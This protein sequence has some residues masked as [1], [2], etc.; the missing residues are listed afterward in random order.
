[1]KSQLAELLPIDVLGEKRCY[2]VIGAH[3]S[4]RIMVSVWVPDIVL[5]ASQ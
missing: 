3:P 5:Q 2:L 1:M 4:N